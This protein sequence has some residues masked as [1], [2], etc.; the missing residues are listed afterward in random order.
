M[1]E[2]LLTQ[3]NE[4]MMSFISQLD[5]IAGINLALAPPFSTLHDTPSPMT[6]PPAPVD[7]LLLGHGA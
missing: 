5:G 3:L 2:A 7:V 4:N 6:E 1:A